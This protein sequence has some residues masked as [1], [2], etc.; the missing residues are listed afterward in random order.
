[1]SKIAQALPK[2]LVFR[3]SSMRA[4]LWPNGEITIWSQKTPELPEEAHPM[5][6][7]PSDPKQLELAEDASQDVFEA[8][9]ELGLVNAGNFDKHQETHT[10]YGLQGITS[11]GRKVVRNACH[12]FKE[13]SSARFLSF[14]TVTLPSLPY[15]QMAAIHE[16]WHKIVDAYRR[17]VRRQLMRK[18]LP[19]EIIGVTEI[20]P[21]R[22][23]ETGDPVLHCHFIWIGRKRGSDWAI[24]PEKHDEIWLRAIRVI[25]DI[26]MSAV[27]SAAK[28]QPIKGDPSK[29]M[30]KYIS[31]GPEDIEAVIAEGFEWW[32][33][34]QWWNCTRSLSR[35]IVKATKIFAEGS[36]WLVDL[37]LEGNDYFWE[38]FTA[39]TAEMPDN[40]LITV[41]YSG[42]LTKQAADMVF[43]EF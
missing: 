42:K 40:K 29:Y 21:K 28:I 33:P 10:R 6:H 20:Q 4:R 35:R 22:F 25:L 12:M 23:A 17:E 41:A 18:G 36:A 16:N 43:A 30:G 34:K 1:M 38:Y 5:G 2:C 26:P 13:E 31:K 37:G 19:G 9:A 32:L 27:K 8:S 11:H 15:D 14:A 39:V 3:R 7:K 24:K